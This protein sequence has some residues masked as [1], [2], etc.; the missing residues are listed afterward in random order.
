MEKF[1]MLESE[2]KVRVGDNTWAEIIFEDDSKAKIYPNTEIFL[3][4]I[5]EKRPEGNILKKF[6]IS[7][8]SGK[9]VSSIKEHSEVYINTSSCAARVKGIL[10]VQV[11]NETTIAVLDGV[12]EVT[13][14][15]GKNVVVVSS[16]QQVMIAPEKPLPEP[17]KI[18]V[19][20]LNELNTEKEHIEK[21]E[22]FEQARQT[23][24]Q[25]LPM[26]HPLVIEERTRRE[27]AKPEW[28]QMMRKIEEFEKK[29]KQKIAER[30]KPSGAFSKMIVID[31]SIN[32]Q[33]IEFGIVSA[34]IRVEYKNSKSS[35]DKTFLILNIRAKNNSPKQ[36]FV[37]YGEEVRLFSEYQEVIPLEDYG[38]ETDLEPNSEVKGFLLFLVPKK[39][40]RFKLQFGKKSL[41]KVELELDL[42][43]KEKGLNHFRRQ[44]P[45]PPE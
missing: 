30:S 45:S 17:T 7:I 29:H 44:A 43:E 25:S 15:E 13:D 4:E 18:D 19:K 9:I 27:M 23:V 38:M 24:L 5:K 41:P 28:Q 33:G 22:S 40:T 42:T 20:L 31:K 26:Y 34:E 39:D 32:Y 12:A 11:L 2:E 8:F 21:I 1:A 35:E 16:C 37:F 6:A 10:L 14:R 36:V 3:K